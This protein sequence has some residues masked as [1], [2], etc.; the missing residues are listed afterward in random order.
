MPK[1]KFATVLPIS[2]FVIAVILLQLGD[3][4]LSYVHT[5]RLVCWGLNA[6]AMVSRGLGLLCGRWGLPCLTG[7]IAGFYTDDLFFLAGVVVVWYLV[8]RALDQ[9]RTSQTVREVGRAMTLIAC[10]LLLALGGLLLLLG[11]D[12]LRNPRFNSP[13]YPVVAVPMLMWSPS[14]IFL[15]GR[16]LV[17]AIRHALRV[18]VRTAQ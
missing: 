7:P 12:Y 13:N 6:P 3:P 10:S 8:G 9:R 1:L 5:A 11:L 4:R 16:G 17:R 18:S 15:S 2:Q 14:L